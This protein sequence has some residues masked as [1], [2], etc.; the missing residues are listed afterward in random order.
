ME[1]VVLSGGP[2]QIVF[3]HRCT[4]S[5]KWSSGTIHVEEGERR[6]HALLMM[7]DQMCRGRE[8]DGR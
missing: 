3:F 7:V 6:D 4:E 1:T 5:L 2:A 8:S